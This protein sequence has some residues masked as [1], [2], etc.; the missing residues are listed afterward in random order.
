[1]RRV[2]RKALT[3]QQDAR[4]FLD[5][6]MH[7]FEEILFFFHL[8]ATV[9]Q[10][11]CWTSALDVGRQLNLCRHRFPGLPRDLLSSKSFAAWEFVCWGSLRPMRRRVRLEESL[12]RIQES[13]KRILHTLMSQ[14]SN[15]EV[16]TIFEII[17]LSTARSSGHAFR[18]LQE[19]KQPDEFYI[20]DDGAQAQFG[21]L[22]FGRILLWNLLQADDMST[23]PLLTLLEPSMQAVRPFWKQPKKQ[24]CCVGHFGQCNA[25]CYTNI[26]DKEPNLQQGA[27]KAD[28][29]CS[30]TISA[31]KSKGQR[32]SV[33]SF[34]V[35]IAQPVFV[36][37]ASPIE[38]VNKPARE[39][40]GGWPWGPWVFRFQQ[41]VYLK[42]KALIMLSRN[43]LH[44]KRPRNFLQKL[45][46]AHLF[47]HHT[48]LS[49][50]NM[51]RQ[52]RTGI[53]SKCAELH[54]H[55]V[56][57]LW[58]HTGGAAW[59]RRG[60]GVWMPRL[61]EWIT[62]WSYYPWCLWSAFSPYSKSR[63]AL[64]RKEFSSFHCSACVC[65]G[66]QRGSWRVT[67]RTLSLSVTTTRELEKNSTDHAFEEPLAPE[68][69]SKFPFFTS[70]LIVL[71]RPGCFFTG[72]LSQN[73]GGCRQDESCRQVELMKAL[74]R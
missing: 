61:D 1:M 3:L 35:F 14:I 50:E 12:K 7:F 20:G 37:A 47:S 6:R 2:Q 26:R 22:H 70:H 9:P 40:V 29:D 52:S 46:T 71:P 15:A 10:T 69:A 74:F 51:V 38:C 49:Y 39:G 66:R 24:Q 44:L 63:T 53:V 30:W 58:H 18:V 13:L 5:Q 25:P 23:D 43:H 32:C 36:E 19:K 41:L 28:S 33:K 64:Q 21:S 57:T 42:K 62:F 60:G 67:L 48:S 31:F 68:E 11:R 45:I 4:K 17:S 55:V 8:Q 34:Q 65:G 16:E 73:G 56:I 54:S 27:W 59:W 72:W